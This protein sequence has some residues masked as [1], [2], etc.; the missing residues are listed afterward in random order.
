MDQQHSLKSWGS[1]LLEGDQCVN[2]GPVSLKHVI[3][4]GLPILNG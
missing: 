4:S 1:V 3:E 2:V